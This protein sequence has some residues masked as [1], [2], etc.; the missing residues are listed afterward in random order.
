MSSGQSKY[1]DTVQLPETAFPMRGDLARRE[2]E[3]LAQWTKTRLYHRIQEAR[4][5][6]DEAIAQVDHIEADQPAQDHI[7]DDRKLDQAQ[8][9]AQE[10]IEEVQEGVHLGRR[11]PRWR[12]PVRI[13]AARP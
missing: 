11:R 6:V 2:P 13:R 10:E 9:V 7:G 1:K 12:W 8:Q 5:A 4:D 3:I